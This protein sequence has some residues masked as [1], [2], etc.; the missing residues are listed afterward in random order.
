MFLGSNHSVG[1]VGFLFDFWGIREK[2]WGGDGFSCGGW[3]FVFHGGRPCMN[4]GQP[5]A[6]AAI[7]AGPLGF[8]SGV[9]VL[10]QLVFKIQLRPH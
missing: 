2:R 7:G 8:G 10:V 4:R 9:P 3:V 5:F 6:G 1:G